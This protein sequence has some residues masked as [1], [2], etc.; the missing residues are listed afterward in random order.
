MHCCHASVNS[1]WVVMGIPWCKLMVVPERVISQACTGW[2]LLK[3]DL[4]SFEGIYITGYPFNHINVL[5]GSHLGRA[6]PPGIQE[7]YP[8]LSRHEARNSRDA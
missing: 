7:K 1:P 8:P 2:H 6:G 5:T 4:F 3:L